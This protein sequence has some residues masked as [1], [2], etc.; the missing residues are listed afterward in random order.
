MA[1][2][3]CFNTFNTSPYIG[4]EPDVP[5]LIKGVGNA[6]FTLIGLDVYSLDAYAAM[7]GSLT[8]VAALLKSHGVR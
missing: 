4:A 6:G 5:A 2:S 1:V 8:D 7:G 3:L